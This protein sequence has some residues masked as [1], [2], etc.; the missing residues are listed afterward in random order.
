MR[1]FLWIIA[2][3]YTHLQQHSDLLQGA[4]LFSLDYSQIFEMAQEDDFI[5]DRKSVV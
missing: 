5:L 4:E 1:F 2:V 3:S